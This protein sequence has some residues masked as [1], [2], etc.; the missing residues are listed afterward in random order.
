MASGY[1]MSGG[2]RDPQYHLGCEAEP[3]VGFCPALC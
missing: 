3:L 1:V 2:S